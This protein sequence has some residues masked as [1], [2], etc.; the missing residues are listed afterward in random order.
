[1]N[2]EELMDFFEKH[3]SVLYGVCRCCLWDWVGW[4][5]FCLVECGC[6]LCENGTMIDTS[7]HF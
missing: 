7:L 3:R 5:G 6:F 4:R 2:R 1:M